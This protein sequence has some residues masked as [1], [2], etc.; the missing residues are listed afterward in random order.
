MSNPL[1]GCDT[2]DLLGGTKPSMDIVDLAL[3]Y[4]RIATVEGNLDCSVVLANLAVEVI[5]LRDK[6]AKLE[7][8]LYG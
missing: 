1:D 8:Y 2:Y 7:M 6:A 3:H 4:Q 5:R